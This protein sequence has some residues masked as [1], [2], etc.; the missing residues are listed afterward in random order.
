MSGGGDDGCLMEVLTSGGSGFTAA[1]LGVCRSIPSCSSFSSAHQLIRSGQGL[2]DASLP[3]SH[4]LSFSFS[5]NP[6]ICRH[7]TVNKAAAQPSQKT[8]SLCRRSVATFRT[9]VK[10][11]SS[12]ETADP[13]PFQQEV[14]ENI[15]R[16]EPK[17]ILIIFTG[18]INP[19]NVRS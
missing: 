6:G 4:D 16:L 17:H 19:V 13:E 2:R 5:L 15:R 1:A 10:G 3:G 14:L 11:Q 9:E 12:S 18:T 7:V 8:A